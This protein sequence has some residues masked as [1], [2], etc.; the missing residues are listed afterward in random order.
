MH[1][2]GH[3]RQRL[4]GAGAD[5]RG[6]QKLR[7]V[8]RPLLGRGRQRPMQAPGD[9]VPRAHVVMVGHG[10]VRQHRLG[11]RGRRL[12]RRQGGELAHHSIGPMAVQES[13]LRGSRG[14]GAA[15]RE[16]DDLALPP[17]LDRGVRRVDEAREALGEP[18]VSARLAAS[19]VHPLLDDHPLAVVRDDEAVQVQVESVL[20]GG[21]VHLGH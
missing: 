6:E 14:F 12:R 21:A 15:V 18:V 1:H 17:P 3:Q 8:L 19:V 9:H 7:E 2:L 4:H 16:I 10:E 20:H 5:T 11:R 13:H